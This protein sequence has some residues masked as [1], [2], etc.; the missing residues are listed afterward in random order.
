MLRRLFLAAASALLLAR[1]G[2][3]AEPAPASRIVFRIETAGRAI[4]WA[5]D[6]PVPNRDL[7]LFHRFPGGTLM[8]VRRSDVR[9]IS[10]EA[11]AAPPAKDT[12]GYLDIG[13]TGGGSRR[14][15]T[16]VMAGVPGPAGARAS[17]KEPPGP[18]A[19]PDGTA[20]FNPD[21]KYQPDIDAKQVPGSSTGF[22]N[23]ANDYREGRTFGY[24]AAPAVQSAP[25]EP[26]RMAPSSGE[27]PKGPQ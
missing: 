10:Q 14:D 8:S 9:R 20:L 16:P 23:S 4:L 22:P 26:P 17:R 13:A 5:E 12:Y 19:R 27:V 3:A 11:W 24:P 6:R 2:E 21:R 25:G 18:G 15:G 1:S 7:L